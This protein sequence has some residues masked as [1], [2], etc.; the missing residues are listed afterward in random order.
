MDRNA[1]ILK[2]GSLIY[3]GGLINPYE[4]VGITLNENSS[5]ILHLHDFSDNKIVYSIKNSLHIYN[6]EKYPQINTAV[7]E[8]QPNQRVI[9]SKFIGKGLVM[10]LGTEN[11][12]LIAHL[13]S[14]DAKLWSKHILSKLE[15]PFYIHN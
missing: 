8:G 3:S 4:C 13:H 11:S 1:K 12:A 5:N 10:T 14:E 6:P 9:V 2:N 7:L 15:D